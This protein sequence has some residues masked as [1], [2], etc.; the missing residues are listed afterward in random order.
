MLLDIPPLP[1]STE[2]RRKNIKTFWI[3]LSSSQ[4]S[5]LMSKQRHINFDALLTH[6]SQR[7]NVHYCLS[8]IVRR[9]ST[10]THKQHGGISPNFTEMILE[11]SPFIFLQRFLFHAEFLLPWQP[12]GKTLKIFLSKKYMADLKIIWYKWSLMTL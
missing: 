5:Y 12:K 7:L 2:K 11:W 6:L 9:S 8:S 3:R 1:S 10:S 4:Q